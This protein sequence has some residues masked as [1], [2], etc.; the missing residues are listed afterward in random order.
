MINPTVQNEWDDFAETLKPDATPEQVRLIRNAF[1]AGF[2]SSLLLLQDLAHAA[3][4]DGL[5]ETAARAIVDGLRD[6][7]QM[8]AR[9]I[10]TELA[11]A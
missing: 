8:F 5:S 7:L 1:Y 9:D 4:S 11:N 6:E 3:A 2:M 10:R